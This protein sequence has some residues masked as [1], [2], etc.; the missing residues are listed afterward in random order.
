[1]NDLCALCRAVL[2]ILWM[3][4][5]TLQNESERIDQYLTSRPYVHLW[6]IRDRMDRWKRFRHVTVS[7]MVFAMTSLQP[8]GYFW[9]FFVNKLTPV[10]AFINSSRWCMCCIYCYTTCSPVGGFGLAYIFWCIRLYIAQIGITF[11]PLFLPKRAL[12]KLSHR[13]IKR[14]FYEDIQSHNVTISFKSFR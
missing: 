1:M 5:K 14:T 11:Y 7:I 3:W 4:S 13:H 10:P 8:H 9:M 2:Y 12:L 6:L